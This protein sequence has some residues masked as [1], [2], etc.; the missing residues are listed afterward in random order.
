MLNSLCKNEARLEDNLT[1]ETLEEMTVV[2][3]KLHEQELAM[4]KM[5]QD[6]AFEIQRRDTEIQH[7]AHLASTELEDVVKRKDF[8]LENL[9]SELAQVKQKAVF[10]LEKERA[11][12]ETQI[13]SHVPVY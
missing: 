11:E 13:Q 6:A 12:Y 3:Q 8:E 7:K 4:Q 9:Q 5:H 10:D 1:S 2:R